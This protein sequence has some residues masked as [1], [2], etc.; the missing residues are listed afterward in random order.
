MSSPPSIFIVGYGP[1]IAGAV[2]SLFATKGFSLGLISRNPIA[3]SIPGAKIAIESADGLKPAEVVAALDALKA[4]LGA[5][6]VVVYNVAGLA[7]G[8]GEMMSLK[9]E[10]LAQ[11]FTIG[12][13]GGLAVA[14]W[15]AKHLLG[16]KKTVRIHVATVTVCG[17]VDGDDPKYQKERIAPV[18]LK[19]YEQGVEGEAEIIY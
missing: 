1:G 4:K 3:P 17:F 18:Y 8:M 16:D 14:Q 6:E 9:L 19:L 7:F 2:A 12:P 5:P 11:H 10:T 15:S 13:V